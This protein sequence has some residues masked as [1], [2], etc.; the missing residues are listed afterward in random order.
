M[1]LSKGLKAQTASQYAFLKPR[2]CLPRRDMYDQI[3]TEYS[4]I[5][6][7]I[8]FQKYT[9]IIAKFDEY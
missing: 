3:S 8:L 1:A 5:N 4:K 2:G 9:S 7:L 6:V